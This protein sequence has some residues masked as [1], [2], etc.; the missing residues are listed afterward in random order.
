MVIYISDMRKQ[1]GKIHNATQIRYKN[2]VDGKMHDAT[3]IG[4]EKVIT[5][6]MHVD[7]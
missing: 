4:Y 1:F 6:M 3:Q 7:M 2:V 5:G